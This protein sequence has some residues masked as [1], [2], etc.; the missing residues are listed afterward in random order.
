MKSLP[1][2]AGRSAVT[3]DTS[4]AASRRQVHAAARQAAPIEGELRT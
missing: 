2:T 3:A 1:F 4:T